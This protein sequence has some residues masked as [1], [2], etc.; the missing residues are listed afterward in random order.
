MK[1]TPIAL[2]AALLAL[3]PARGD[4]KPWEATGL[5]LPAPLTRVKPGYLKVTATTEAKRVKFDVEADFKLE[6]GETLDDVGFEFEKEGDKQV[7]VA[8]PAR[9]GVIRVTAY[10]VVGD[11]IAVAKTLITVQPKTPP[12]PPAPAPAPSPPPQPDRPPAGGGKVAS[13]YFVIDADQGD[14]AVAALVTGKD[15]RDGI[16]RLGVKPRALPSTSSA[17]AKAGLAE[18]VKAVGLPA[19]ILKDDSGKI[20]FQGKVPASAAEVLALIARGG[21]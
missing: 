7:L 5:T 4:G 10:A 19:L 13:A 2:L 18:P 20:I 9:E 17:V 14:P 1:A 11:D 3:A 16:A 8:V 6:S 15:L 21:K 12:A